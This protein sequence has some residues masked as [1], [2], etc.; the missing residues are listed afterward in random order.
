MARSLYISISLA[1]RTINDIASAMSVILERIQD[2]QWVKFEIPGASLRADDLSSVEAKETWPQM[3]LDAL[4]ESSPMIRFEDT[5]D[6]LSAIAEVRIIAEALKLEQ[7]LISYNGLPLT[8]AMD[9]SEQDV[10][11]RF[12]LALEV[13]EN[14]GDKEWS[15]CIP[16]GDCRYTQTQRNASSL[17]TILGTPVAFIFRGT[18]HTVSSDTRLFTH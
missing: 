11:D 2:K 1:G 3:L 18:T 12:M 13:Q 5:T 9:D 15:F 4:A 8:I 14:T 17:N 16:Q 6:F 10:I 7:C